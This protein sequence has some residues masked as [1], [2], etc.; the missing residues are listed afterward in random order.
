MLEPQPGGLDALG[1]AA[2][3]DPVRVAEQLTDHEP[4]PRLED[5]GE[6]AQRGPLVGDLTCMAS[7]WVGTTLAIPASAARRIV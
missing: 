2:E 3:R 5:S 4:T 1:E 6:L 7:P